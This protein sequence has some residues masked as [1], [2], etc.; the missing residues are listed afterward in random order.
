[1]CPIEAEYCEYTGEKGTIFVESK[2][3]STTI[4]VTGICGC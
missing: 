3:N 1:M 4:Q 2:N